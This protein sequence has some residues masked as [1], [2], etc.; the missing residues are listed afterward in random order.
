[1]QLAYIR[2]S[3][4]KAKYYCQGL[5]CFE[6]YVAQMRTGK[7][8]YFFNSN[9]E[10]EAVVLELVRFK[11]FSINGNCYLLAGQKMSEKFLLSD[12]S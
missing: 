8:P 4:T 11:F 3:V 7:I 2:P 10:S 1:M 9:E 12:L 5:T 6:S